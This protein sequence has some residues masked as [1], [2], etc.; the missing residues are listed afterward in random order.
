MRYLSADLKWSAMRRDGLPNL[1]LS[2]RVRLSMVD[3]VS[4]IQ[5]G[6]VEL[7][8]IGLP[9]IE[10]IYGIAGVCRAITPDETRRHGLGRRATS[11]WR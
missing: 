6:A 1:P 3:G 10:V 9:E 2:R 11:P 7:G 4:G 5:C 8:K